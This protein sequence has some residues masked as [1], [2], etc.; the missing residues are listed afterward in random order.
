[1]P[2]L[3]TALV[4]FCILNVAVPGAFAQ[5]HTPARG[6]PER[7]AILDSLRPA[8]EAQLN[9]P[10]EFVVRTMNVSG[11]WAFVTVDPRRPGGGKIALNTTRISDP[12]FLDGLT[13]YALLKFQ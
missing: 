8:I 11:G 1:M 4:L 13:T 7:A 12:S 10:V 3:F 6:T 9:P 5:P 2:K